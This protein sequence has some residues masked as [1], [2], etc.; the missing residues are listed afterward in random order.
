MSHSP[1]LQSAGPGL[2]RLGGY[3]CLKATESGKGVWLSKA[4]KPSVN[5]QSAGQKPNGRLLC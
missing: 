5:Q 2:D 4:V 1:Y 3:G